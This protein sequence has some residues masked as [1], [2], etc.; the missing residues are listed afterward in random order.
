VV[1]VILSGTLD[2]GTAGLQMVKRQG[3][4]AVVQNPDDALFG[5][6]PTSAITNVEVDYCLPVHDIPALLTRLATDPAEKGVKIVA[7]DPAHER[8]DQQPLEAFTQ[9]DKQPGRPSLYTCP[10]CH[11]T[12]W[13]LQDG[14]FVHYK[15]RTG[16]QF[17][18]ESL[19]D[20]QSE[21]LEGALWGAMRAL[22]EKASLARR[23]SLRAQERAHAL[24]ASRFEAQAED[25]ERSVDVIRALLTNGTTT[26]RSED[27]ESA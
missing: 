22:E 19:L 8:D 24:A 25:A 10:D 1:G 20:S 5:G 27:S 2:D 11:G 9:S 13:E 6:M 21:A 15:C 4:V 12:L 18:P 23:L 17:S 14:Q 7:D 16:H 3:G 26:E